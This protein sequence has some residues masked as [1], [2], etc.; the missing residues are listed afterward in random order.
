MAFSVFCLY[1]QFSN[2]ILEICV[3]VCTF[4]ADS[5]YANDNIE[6]SIIILKNHEP[7][8]LPPAVNPCLTADNWRK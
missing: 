4:Y 1:L 2:K 6:M 5:N 3:Y 7:F 8:D